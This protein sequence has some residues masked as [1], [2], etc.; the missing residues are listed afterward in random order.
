MEKYLTAGEVA[1]IAGRAQSTVRYWR[2]VGKGPTSV[3]IGRQ[4]LYL[5]SAVERFMSGGDTERQQSAA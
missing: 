3:K 5:E 2:M 1:A 4:Y